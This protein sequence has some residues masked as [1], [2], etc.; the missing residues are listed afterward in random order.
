MYVYKL[1][2]QAIDS[3]ILIEVVLN[4]VNLIALLSR[5]VI[6]L[7]TCAKRGAIEDAKIYVDYLDRKMTTELPRNQVMSEAICVLTNSYVKPQ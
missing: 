2:F 5:K 7:P 3:S 1:I 4:N 6:M